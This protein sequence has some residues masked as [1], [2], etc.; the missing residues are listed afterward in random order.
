MTEETK[1]EK[2]TRLLE[3]RLPNVLKGME[4]VGNLATGPSYEFTAD[5][6]ENVISSLDAATATL[7]EQFGVQR[8]SSAASVDA[9]TA[10]V[11]VEPDEP[12]PV[13]QKASKASSAPRTMAEGELELSK[14]ETLDLIGATGTQ[15]NAAIN[16]LEDND[17]DRAKDLLLNLMRS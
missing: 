11:N 16:A 1:S 6:A 14:V 3:K 4:L 10:P 13:T 12:K 9:P 8:G 17:P 15:I 7:A 5:Q 2:F